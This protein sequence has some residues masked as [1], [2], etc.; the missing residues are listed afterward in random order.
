VAIRLHYNLVMEGLEWSKLLVQPDT[1][2]KLLSTY[3]GSYP[4]TFRA[5]MTQTIGSP[6]NQIVR[7]LFTLDWLERVRS[8]ALHLTH[9]PQE[10]TEYRYVHAKISNYL[11]NTIRTEKQKTKSAN[12]NEYGAHQKA[13]KHA[14]RRRRVCFVLYTLIAPFLTQFK[15]AGRR[16]VTI[17]VDTNLREQIYLH[18]IVGA[19]GESDEYTDDDD[20]I[21]S[22]KTVWNVARMPWRNRQYTQLLHYTDAVE[23]SYLTSNFLNLGG[24]TIRPAPRI[25]RRYNDKVKTGRA[26]P[27]KL[28]SIAYDQKHLDDAKKYNL[29][30]R[31]QPDNTE[32]EPLPTMDMYNRWSLLGDPSL[33]VH[34][35]AHKKMCLDCGE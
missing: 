34:W 23:Q 3:E 31:I 5:D 25:Q 9:L 18:S 24:K 1:L 16:R 6:W 2:T 10:A 28:P 32:I 21:Q 30:L 35:S 29:L 19:E 8:G 7:M 12:S 20:T 11:K 26:M 22:L 17:S 13:T 27:V 4:H 33:S 15:K 14:E